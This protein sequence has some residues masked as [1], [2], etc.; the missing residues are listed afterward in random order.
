M[1]EPACTR[2]GGHE[3]PDGGCLHCGWSREETLADD[4]AAARA[5]R[6]RLTRAQGLAL[7]P[8]VA[9]HHG[10]LSALLA[11]RDALERERDD[12]RRAQRYAEVTL[13]D[14]TLDHKEHDDPQV[15]RTLGFWPDC[16][17]G[18]CYAIHCLDV[19]LSDLAAARG[20]L[21]DILRWHG[22]TIDAR[23][24]GLFKRAAHIAAT[25]EREPGA[26]R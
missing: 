4:L 3:W 15:L 19:A 6:E 7:W 11:D 10:H 21:H 16:K 5:I 20:L 9:V 13:R 23:D 22:D 24:P 18:A 12:A 17:C 26:A 2:N 25:P 8:L 14:R 1:M